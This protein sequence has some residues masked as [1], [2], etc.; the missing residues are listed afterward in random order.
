MNKIN[1][2]VYKWTP[3]TTNK[4]KYLN[5][6][7][8]YFSEKKIKMNLDTLIYIN[9]N[10]NFNL[11]FRRSCREGICGSCAM[12]INGLNK[13]ACLTS[14]DN[15]NIISPL[16]HLPLR[17]DLIIDFKWFYSQLFKI[18]PWIFSKNYLNRW[19]DFSKKRT[20]TLNT[21]QTIFNR[22]KLDGLY[23]CIL[24]ACCSTSCPSY[25]WNRKKYLGPAI[26]LQ[27]YRW[28]IDTRDSA[29]SV[30]INNLLDPFK[31]YRCHMILNCSQTCP[32]GL[33][34]SVAIS[35]IKKYISQHILI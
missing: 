13:L 28:I 20:I 9:N 29:F 30:R 31:V 12:N 6:K 23:E 1:F 25:W 11:S 26:L 21:N 18:K 16:P 19:L 2:K 3:Y 24:C 7:F 34:P 22:K 14:V 32:K 17:K 15:N 10:S 33:K 27:S 8:N 35:S 4:P 5:Y